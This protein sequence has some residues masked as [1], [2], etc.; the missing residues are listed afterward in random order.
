MENSCQTVVNVLKKTDFSASE[1]NDILLQPRVAPSWGASLKSA[2]R[3][4]RTEARVNHLCVKPAFSDR[5]SDSALL[6]DTA[7]CFLHI[8]EIDLKKKP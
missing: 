1:C 4:S 8:R 7:D 2:P 5:I 6:W 3:I